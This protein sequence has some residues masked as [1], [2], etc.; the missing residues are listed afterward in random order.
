MLM[1]NGTN[2]TEV[3]TTESTT[4]STE[5]ELTDE[6]LPYSQDEETTPIVSET[7]TQSPKTTENPNVASVTHSNALAFMVPFCIL[8]STKLL[9]QV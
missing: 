3:S 1:S 6:T 4:L 8:F 9:G 2:A 5:D 7:S